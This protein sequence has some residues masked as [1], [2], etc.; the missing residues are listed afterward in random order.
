MSQETAG[1]PSAAETT[2]PCRAIERM[3]HPQAH[4][5][6]GF[7]VRRALPSSQQ[8]MVGPWIFFDHMGPAEFQPAQGIDVRPHPHI[9]LATVTYLFE[10]E[11]LH[12]DSLG[13]EQLIQPGAINLMVAGRGIVH[14]E[15]QRDEIKARGNRLEGLQLWLAL[16]AADEETEPAFHHYPAEQ[17]PETDVD[18]VTVRLL[19]GE[20][21]GVR[22]PVKMFASTLYAE[23]TLQAGQQLLLPQGVAER[24]VYVTAGKLSAMDGPIDAHSMALLSA[25]P[26]IAVKAEQDSRIAIIGGDPVG[27]RHIW[28]NFVSSRQARIEQA[29]HEWRTGQFAKVPGDEQEFIPLPEE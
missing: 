13:H 4:D 10:G 20:A 28:W 29:K 3:I 14:S 22:S 21:Y 25:E 11:M 18:G 15:R 12:R 7:V 9:N 23:A 27:P 26:D 6:G 1:T 16:P 24:A 2:G 5:L 17:I 19:I 8:R